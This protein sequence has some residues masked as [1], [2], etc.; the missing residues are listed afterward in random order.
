MFLSSE[1]NCADCL[2]RMTNSE[3]EDILEDEEDLIVA[4]VGE[5]YEQPIIGELRD[6]IRKGWPEKVRDVCDIL[7]P[8]W[9]YRDCLSVSDNDVV[10]MGSRVVIP[11]SEIADVLRSAHDGHPGIGRIKAKLRERVF[12]PQMNRDIENFVRSCEGCCLSGK[13]AKAVEPGVEA[14]SIPNGPFETIHIDFAGPSNLFAGSYCFVVVDGFSKWPEV[15][16]CNGPTSKNAIKFLRDIFAR[17]GVPMKLVSDNGTAFTSS[18]FYRFAKEFGLEH[19]TTSPYHQ[20]SNGQVERLIGTLKNSLKSGASVEEF[21]ASYRSIRHPAT[22][23]RPDELC[24]GRKIRTKLDVIVSTGFSESN[25]VSYVPETSKNYRKK[26]FKAKR[27]RQP[28]VGVLVRVKRAKENWSW[29][30]LRIVESIGRKMFRLESGQIVHAD[31]LC[32]CREDL[33]AGIDPDEESDFDVLED[34]YEGDDVVDTSE[35]EDEH[36]DV[37][38]EPFDAEKPESDVLPRTT[39]S[40][41]SFNPYMN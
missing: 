9:P 35:T 4:C 36:P 41:K 13:N 37:E 14:R 10:L 33:D 12:W 20:S 39:R 6:M 15:F 23:R 38:N 7:K 27:G 40:G 16:A 5:N 31:Q 25:P 3:I 30:P 26:I 29:P 21:L 8:Y 17:L 28:R 18:E 22:G 2:S 34:V 24:I 11:N 32:L 1:E 19:E